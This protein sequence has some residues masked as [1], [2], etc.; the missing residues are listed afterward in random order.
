MRATFITRA[1]ENGA[2]LED[3]QHAVGHEDPSTTRL[4]DRRRMN[5]ERS[6]S[7]YANY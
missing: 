4:Y 6:A 2:S 3:V 7:F 5:P 1:L